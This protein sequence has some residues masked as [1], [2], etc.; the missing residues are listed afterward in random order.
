MSKKTPFLVFWTSTDFKQLTEKKT[1]CLVNPVDSELGWNLL[2]TF[3]RWMIFVNRIFRCTKSQW[4][5]KETEYTF[6]NWDNSVVY[7]LRNF[8]SSV[9]LLQVSSFHSLHRSLPV[10]TKIEKFLQF[11]FISPI[12]HWKHKITFIFSATIKLCFHKLNKVF[13][14]VV[15]ES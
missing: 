14:K 4:M 8:L 9:G 10:Q 5:P 2:H 1:E 7:G 3:R 13:A 12:H 15:F 11:L 6:L